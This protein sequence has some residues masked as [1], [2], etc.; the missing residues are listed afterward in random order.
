[1]TGLLT[2]LTTLLTRFAQAASCGLL[3]AMFVLINVEI[4]CRYI[5]STS[6]LIADE[7]SAYFFATMVYLGLSQAIFEDKNIKIDVPG[8][9]RRLVS[10]T[11]IR[12]VLGVVICSFNAVL[13]YAMYLT[14]ST[15]VLFNSKSIQASRTLL[16]YPQFAVLAALVI[17]LLVTVA[18]TVLSLCRS[19]SERGR[20][21]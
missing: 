6:T 18:T 12:F 14:V 8:G 11:P 3:A 16:A 10:C 20:S 2:R 7:Y 4:V 17:V 21:K 19:P 15:S 5:F 9:W 1:M 13:V